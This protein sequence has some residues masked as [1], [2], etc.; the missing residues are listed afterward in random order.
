MPATDFEL[1]HARMRIL[2]SEG[3]DLRKEKAA[4]LSRFDVLL[5]NRRMLLAE[6]REF[7]VAAR[8][9]VRKASSDLAGADQAIRP[10][11]GAWR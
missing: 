4:L 11:E 9:R 3:D 8:A 6:M 1:Q 10:K 5:A 2:H 7:A